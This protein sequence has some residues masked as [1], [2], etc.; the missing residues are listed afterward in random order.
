MLLVYKTQ[1][2]SSR[3]GRNGSPAETH[4]PVSDRVAV[5]PQLW[6]DVG[7]EPAK[8][9]TSESGPEGFSLG[10]VSDVDS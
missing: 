10:N 1:I 4:H 3:R 2:F 5:G 9:S 6:V 8:R 7:E